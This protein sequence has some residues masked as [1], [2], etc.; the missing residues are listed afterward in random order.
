MSL[1]LVQLLMNLKS[2]SLLK[3]EYLIIKNSKKSLQLVSSLYKEGFI[4]SY[5]VLRNENLQINLRYFF[6]KPVFINLKILSF[7]S[8]TRYVKLHVLSKIS[9]KKFTLFIST[10]RGILTLEDCKKYNLSGVLLFSC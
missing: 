5:K 10:S 2:Y 4:Q 8:K 3:K 9:T 7:P 6:N 1:Q